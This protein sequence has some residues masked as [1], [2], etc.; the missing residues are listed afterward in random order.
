M[1]L[2]GTLRKSHLIRQLYFRTWLIRYFAAKLAKRKSFSQAEE[3]RKIEELIGEVGWFVDIGAH[4]GISGSNT[5]YFAL[6]GARGLCFE[7]VGETYTKL[8]WLYALNPRVHTLRCGI[9]D[10]SREATMIAADFLSCLP[11][12]EDAAHTAVSTTHDSSQESVML[13]RF[14]DAIQ[15]MSLPA[16]CDLLSIDVE[17]HELNVLKSIDFSQHTF[18]AVVVET[19]LI[20]VRGHYKWRHRDLVEIEELLS[21]CN[22][23]AADHTWV[24]TIYLHVEQWSSERPRSSRFGQGKAIPYI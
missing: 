21:K 9:S 4:D 10:Q 22:Y 23:R 8:K 20:D 24:N 12:T 16:K 7:P 2:R 5:L 1:N 17:G 18:R 13:R 3:D 14:E 6:R 11:E 19:H 15:G